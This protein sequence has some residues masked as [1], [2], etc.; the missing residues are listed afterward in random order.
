MTIERLPP[1]EFRRRLETGVALLLDVRR[2]GALKRDA[3]GIRGAVPILIDQAEAPIPD[4]DRHTEMLVYCLC[5]GQA[6]ST[7]A[8]LWLTRAGYENVFVLEGGLPAWQASGYETAVVSVSD[9]QRVRQWINVPPESSSTASASPMI[10]E[11]AFLAGQKLPV[12]REMAVLFVD[13][14]DSTRL[15]SQGTAEEV[16]ALVQ[17]FMAVVVEVA[18]AH[19]G[20][21]HDFEGDGAMLYFA[22]PGEAVPAAFNLLGALS[23]K[24]TQVPA[25]PHARLALDFGPLVVGHVGTKERRGLSFIGPSINTA[26]R[27]LKL[28]PADGIVGT[29]KVVEHARRSDPDLAAQFR[30]LPERQHLKGFQ[31]PVLVY[32]A[33]PN[34]QCGGHRESHGQE[35]GTPHE[36]VRQ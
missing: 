13:M 27:I 25:L 1:D 23:A 15:L 4:V 36:R 8:A 33:Q 29:G 22:G 7:R 20:D 2:G 34:E 17:A 19:C 16:L 11:A 30:E 9:R 24:R 14:V 12:R 3:T 18:V 31:E 35:Q 10:A 32:V 28:G 21:V 26:A 6:S 5:S